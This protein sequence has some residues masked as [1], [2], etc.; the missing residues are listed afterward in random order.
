MFTY[1]IKHFRVLIILIGAFYMSTSYSSNIDYNSYKKPWFTIEFTTTPMGVDIRL[2]DIPVFNTDDTG[3]ITLEMAV[4]EYIINGNNEIK[5]TTHPRFDDNDE[6]VDSYTEAAKMEVSIYVREESESTDKRKKINKVTIQPSIAYL[7][8]TDQPV[9]VLE[10]N[11]NEGHV[12]LV[13]TKNSKLL[14]YPGYGVYKKQVET[15]LEINN[16]ITKLPPWAWQEG[17]AISGNEAQYQS[18]LKSYENLHNHFLSKNLDAV[19]KMALKR[20]T[21]LSIAY[22]LRDAQAGFEYSA[23]GK[24]I[25]HPTIKIFEKLYLDYTKFDIVGNG[26]LARIMSGARTHPIVFVNHENQQTYNHQFMWY[27]NKNNEWILIR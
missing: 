27:L 22:Y 15:I 14:D 9:A 24:D 3:F 11:T 26:K 4:N 8:S 5:I 1:K 13:P 19:K 18:L 7:E 23:L 2:N 16:L 10:I 25:D 6:Q 20:S 21:E 12:L 17:K